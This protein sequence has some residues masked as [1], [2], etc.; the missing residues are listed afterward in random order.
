MDNKGW[1]QEQDLSLQRSPRQLGSLNREPEY[2]DGSRGYPSLFKA[3]TPGLIVTTTAALVKSHPLD[4]SKV[5]HWDYYGPKI[6]QDW[7]TL[8]H[9]QYHLLFKAPDQSLL[10]TKL[11]QVGAREGWNTTASSMPQS[12]LAICKRKENCSSHGW[13]G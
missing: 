1:G 2:T 5:V 6:T 11:W 12:T 10:Q 9:I 13:G 4:S 8:C 3:T 7:P